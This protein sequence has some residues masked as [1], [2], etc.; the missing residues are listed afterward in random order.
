M[1]PNQLKKAKRLK[2]REA[3]WFAT[4]R[5]AY[6]WIDPPDGPSY[7]PYIVL[8]V[9]AERGR[10]RRTDITGD[11]PAPENVLASLQFER[12]SLKWVF[13]AKREVMALMPGSLTLCMSG[14]DIG[15]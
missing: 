5:R 2:Q 15:A 8:V 12:G 3:T 4:R 10:I 6:T 11:L 9:E 14:S 7:R 1:L 13:T